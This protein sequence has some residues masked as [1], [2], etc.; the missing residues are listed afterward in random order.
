MQVYYMS[1]D[2]ERT[3][4]NEQDILTYERDIDIKRNTI[5]I[6]TEQYPLL[7]E[8]IILTLLDDPRIILKSIVSF[9]RSK[10]RPV[11]RSANGSLNNRIEEIKDYYKNNYKPTGTQVVR[12]LGLPVAQSTFS[13]WKKKNK[14]GEIDD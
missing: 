13:R 1:N 7:T 8:D 14:I 9:V 11:K 4:S 5:K 10:K 2:G 6:L 3:S 12:D